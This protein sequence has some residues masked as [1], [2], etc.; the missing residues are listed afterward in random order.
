MKNN[1]KFIGLLLLSACLLCSSPDVVA[2]ASPSD[3]TSATTR[4][5]NDGDDDNGKWGLAGLIGLVGLLG[6][7]GRDKDYARRTTTTIDR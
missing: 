1:R 5:Y 2:Q 7:R 6:L 3:N 4:D